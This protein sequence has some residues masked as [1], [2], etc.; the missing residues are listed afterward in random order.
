VSGTPIL[1]DTSILIDHLRG[2]EQARDTLLEARRSDRRLLASVLTRT[3]ILGGK[4][5]AETTSTR[6][7]LTA[8]DWIAVSR[9]IADA[10][11]S[12]AREYRTSHSGVDIA[13]YVI[14]AT[15]AAAEAELWTRNVE[16]FPMF[17]GLVAPYRAK[18]P[19][20]VS[21]GGG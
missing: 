13:D 20:M 3:E 6:A 4:R 2:R 16:H 12:L 14:A 8:L 10:A 7:L 17:V 11:G 9:E 21:P 15:A 19:E 18:P 1:V 5:A